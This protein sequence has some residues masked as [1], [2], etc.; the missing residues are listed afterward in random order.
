MESKLHHSINNLKEGVEGFFV[1]RELGILVN[2]P[3]AFTSY[4]ALF[5]TYL[6]D[7]IF[8]RPRGFKFSLKCDTPL[9]KPG[10]T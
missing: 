9:L 5:S 7:E 3:R 10:P 4:L 8:Q 2:G 6:R 1:T